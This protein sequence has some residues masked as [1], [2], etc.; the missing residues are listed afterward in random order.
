MLS[1]NY[2]SAKT[3]KNL[4]SNGRERRLLRTGRVGEILLLQTNSVIVNDLYCIQI[5]VK[6]IE[7]FLLSV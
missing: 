3:T 7:P 6:T 5:G 4:L 2:R 1:F